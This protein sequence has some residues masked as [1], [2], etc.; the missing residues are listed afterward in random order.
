MVD[1]LLLEGVKKGDRTNSWTA[2]PLGAV[3]VR[4]HMQWFGSGMSSPLQLLHRLCLNLLWFFCFA[5]VAPKYCCRKHDCKGMDLFFPRMSVL[6]LFNGI[7][8]LAKPQTLG[9]RF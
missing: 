2:S 3:S 6:T 9:R 7:T 8:L 1:T 4:A 5:Q